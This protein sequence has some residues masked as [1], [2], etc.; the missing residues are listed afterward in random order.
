MNREELNNLMQALK[1]QI[2][3]IKTEQYK[4]K[5]DLDDNFKKDLFSDR[6]L[7]LDLRKPEGTS[8]PEMVAAWVQIACNGPVEGN[9]VVDGLVEILGTKL[10]L[11]T[12]K[13]V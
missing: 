8:L 12:L 11:S 4:A 5:F 3:T 1:S 13:R 2:N 9:I 6:E 7:F 10:P